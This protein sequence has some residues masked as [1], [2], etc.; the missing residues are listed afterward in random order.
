MNET[1]LR[2][3]LKKYIARVMQN[4][5]TDFI[6]MSEPA[7]GFTEEEWKLLNE[8]SKEVQEGK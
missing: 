6:D 3:L 1:Q 7:R 2:E 8:L 4:E 5:G